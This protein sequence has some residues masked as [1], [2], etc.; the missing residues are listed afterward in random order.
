MG[1]VARLLGFGDGTRDLVRDL[2]EAWRSE[3]AH[4]AH[5]RQQASRARYPQ[6][7][8]ALERLAATEDGHAA[9]IRDCL[10]ALGG[11]VPPLAPR[12]LRG[13][14]QWE[15]VVA[16]HHEALAKRKRLLDLIARWDPEAPEAVAVL[17]R[18]ERDDTADLDVYEGL[19]MRSDPQ[20]LD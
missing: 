15:R 10:L 7:G 1:I 2:T 19:V 18:V 3:A 4:A 8:E 11:E 6:V 12:A 5:L 20:A 16:A 13:K 9:A 17:S 14:N